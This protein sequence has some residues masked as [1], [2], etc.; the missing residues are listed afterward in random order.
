MIIKLIYSVFIAFFI[1][2]P[3]SVSI[4]QTLE[5]VTLQDWKNKI[6]G[7]TIKNK[8]CTLSIR[9][10]GKLRGMCQG[11]Q[12]AGSL[13]GS[14]NYGAKGFCRELT[15][16]LST[17]KTRNFPYECQ[18]P[19]WKGD[20]II[21]GNAI[22]KVISNKKSPS[23]DIL[24]QNFNNLSALARK[25]VQ[26]NLQ[27]EGYYKSSIDGSYGKGT[28]RALRNYNS[29]ILGGSDL[30]K[31]S[32]IAILL[33]KLS[34]LKTQKKYTVIGDK[35]KKKTQVDTI[36]SGNKSISSEWE[37]LAE[38]GS[39]KAQYK[40][41]LMYEKGEGFL[42]DFVYAHMWANLSVANG[43]ADAKSLRDKV[44]NKMTPSQMEKA[45]DLARECMKK[46]FKGC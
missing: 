6:V 23:S 11:G 17:G 35:D 33:S 19:L 44:A 36:P 21:F 40:L 1:S 4:G 38:E 32:N 2:L 30:R 25:N 3:L 39:A 18:Q 14:Y 26:L 7:N 12:A 13:I 45:Q 28:E 46:N 16:I 29:D 41:A 20:E 43:Y 8:N 9:K 24:K 10:D 37:A 5:K 42:Q 15:I 31:S 27:A 34:S 22:Y